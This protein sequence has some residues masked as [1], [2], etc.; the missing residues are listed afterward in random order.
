ML[1]NRF[2]YRYV[3]AKLTVQPDSDYFVTLG[4]A[5]PG[6]AVRAD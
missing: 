2:I 5:M 6:S 1:A 3:L 4:K